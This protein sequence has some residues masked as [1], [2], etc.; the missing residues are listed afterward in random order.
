MTEMVGNGAT[1]GATSQTSGVRSGLRSTGMMDGQTTDGILPNEV[2]ADVHCF[3][4]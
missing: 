1:H 3:L 4:E 2:C